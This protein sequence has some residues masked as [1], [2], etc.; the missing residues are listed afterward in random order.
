MATTHTTFICEIKLAITVPD[1][2]SRQQTLGFAS[3]PLGVLQM[4]IGCCFNTVLPAVIIRKIIKCHVSDYSYMMY[5]YFFVHSMRNCLGVRGYNF[6]PPVLWYYDIP[7]H[8]CQGQIQHFDKEG[9]TPPPPQNSKN[10]MIKT[11]HNS[12]ACTTL[13]PFPP[14][15]P[16]SAAAECRHYLTV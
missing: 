8:Q 12:S 5:D 2:I 6:V 16:A 10:L 3:Y 14:P 11:M 15:P 9:T 13:W 1:M 4:I 7:V